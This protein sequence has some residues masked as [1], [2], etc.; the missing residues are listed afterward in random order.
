MLK[1]LA[2]WAERFAN[3]PP[4]DSPSKGSLAFATVLG[5]LMNDVQG[6]P[7]GS[8][9]IFTF[10]APVFANGLSSLSPSGGTGWVST[11]SQAWMSACQASVITP[12]TVTNPAWA[13]SGV[14]VATSPSAASTIGT[15]SAATALLKSGLMEVAEL[16][17]QKNPD[18]ALVLKAPEN[19]AKAFR[20]GTLAFVFTCIGL[21]PGLPPFPVSIPIPA[22]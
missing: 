12:G 21:A 20:N 13:A 4:T 18:P 2:T 22:Q 5:G 3:I 9:G 1:P 11:L 10:A 15:I 19:M 7:T 17:Q 14:D 6:G 16:F 8:P